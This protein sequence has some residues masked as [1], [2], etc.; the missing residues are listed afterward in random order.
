MSIFDRKQPQQETPQEAPQQDGPTLT[1]FNVLARLD[2]IEANQDLIMQALD[3]IRSEATEIAAAT[4]KDM[5]EV[6]TAI[7]T[8]FMTET[9]EIKAGIEAIVEVLSSVNEPETPTN[10]ARSKASANGP[11]A[12][13]DC[14]K[15]AEVVTSWKM[16]ILTPAEDV[17]VCEEH[18]KMMAQQAFQAPKTAKAAPERVAGERAP[19]DKC[20]HG[21][22]MGTDY[23]WGQ[24]HAHIDDNGKVIKHKVPDRESFAREHDIGEGAPDESVLTPAPLDDISAMIEAAYKAKK[25]EIDA[26]LD[27]K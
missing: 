21:V 10:S 7:T 22:D 25:P 13:K 4:S 23:V 20:E 18:A 24:I 19:D 16:D 17:S 12:V 3:Q 26:A 5:L 2:R 6:V 11:C 14:K 15:F 9:I 27:A 1:E 8:A